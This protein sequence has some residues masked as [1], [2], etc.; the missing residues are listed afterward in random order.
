VSS[1]MLAVARCGGTVA[2]DAGQSSATWMNV[3]T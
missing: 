1:A 2:L 3:F